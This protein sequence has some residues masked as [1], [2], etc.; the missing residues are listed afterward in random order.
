[1][2]DLEHA[3]TWEAPDRADSL[4]EYQHM[5]PTISALLTAVT[6]RTLRVWGIA[7]A[8]DDIARAEIQPDF[9]VTH[10]RDSSPSTV[11]GL[12]FVASGECGRRWRWPWRSRRLHAG[13]D[14][15]ARQV[16]TY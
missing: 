2:E 14:L 7:I 5:L 1:M 13:N 12:V 3:S 9:T 10:T 4:R 16:V 6:P 11:G 8:E 15:S